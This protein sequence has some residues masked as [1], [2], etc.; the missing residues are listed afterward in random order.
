[1]MMGEKNTGGSQEEL[2][3]SPATR[4][5]AAVI[6]KSLTE[7]LLLCA[8]VALAAFSYFNPALRGDIAVVDSKHV[9]GWVYDPRTKNERRVLQLYVDDQFVSATRADVSANSAPDST[10]H[11][12][13]FLLP[14]KRFSRGRHRAQV[15]VVRKTPRGSRTLIPVSKEK[16]IFEVTD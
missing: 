5:L 12:F 1:M 15:Y 8:A 4:L 14:E 16:R 10:N 9:E 13:Q 7:T 3:V 11:D 2:I 6:V